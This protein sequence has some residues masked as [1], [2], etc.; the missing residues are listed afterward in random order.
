MFGAGGKKDAKGTL[1]MGSNL[2]EDRDILTN[3]GL[4]IT[5]L[6]VRFITLY[7]LSTG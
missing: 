3:K 5:L 1:K 6:S 7:T 4:D 2:C